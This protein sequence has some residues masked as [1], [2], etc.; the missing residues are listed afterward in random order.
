MASKKSILRKSRKLYESLRSKK[1]KD[2]LKKK[3][4]KEVLNTF[5]E[6]L[7]EIDRTATEARMECL[8]MLRQRAIEINEAFK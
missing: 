4:Y 8:S 1:P 6:Q 2:V 3:M 7:Q 5:E